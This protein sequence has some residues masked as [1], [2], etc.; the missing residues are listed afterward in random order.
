MSAT[1]CWKGGCLVISSPHRLQNLRAKAESACWVSLNP[2]AGPMLLLVAVLHS[3]GSSQRHHFSALLHLCPC[4]ILAFTCTA[5]KQQV[6]GTKA[7]MQEGGPCQLRCHVLCWCRI[8]ACVGPIAAYL[9]HTLFVR[10]RTAA[11][12][13]NLNELL[14]PLLL[15]LLACSPFVMRLGALRSQLL[16]HALS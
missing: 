10:C 2:L 12:W 11:G 15:L 3:L 5:Q 16:P 7:H 13:T 1:F 9:L 4:H 8:H 14:L 6:M